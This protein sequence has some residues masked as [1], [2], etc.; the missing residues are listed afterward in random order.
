MSSNRIFQEK[1]EQYANSH[2]AQ[3]A[4]KNMLNNNVTM[5]YPNKTILTIEGDPYVIKQILKRL[6]GQTI[7]FKVTTKALKS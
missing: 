6:E 3:R 2:R 4:Q 5:L 7:T 1:L